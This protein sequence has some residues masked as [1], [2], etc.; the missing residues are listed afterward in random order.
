MIVANSS[1]VSVSRLGISHKSISNRNSPHST[2]KYD[3]V[4]SFL[5]YQPS[6]SATIFAI[7]SSLVLVIR[8]LLF[9]FL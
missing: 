7:L 4:S 8:V 5:T 2:S 9:I 6:I 1:F 3:S